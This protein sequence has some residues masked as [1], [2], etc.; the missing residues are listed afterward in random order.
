MSPS[1][2]RRNSHAWLLNNLGYRFILE[3][4]TAID[5]C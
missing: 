5:A 1:N 4:K 2:T 3:N